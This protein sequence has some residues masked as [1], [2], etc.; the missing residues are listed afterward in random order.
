[1]AATGIFCLKSPWAY[2]QLP[3]NW[4]VSVYPGTPGEINPGWSAVKKPVDLQI[5]SANPCSGSFS[6]RYT[7]F[8]S[9]AEAFLYDFSGR[10]IMHI[11]L[12]EKMQGTVTAVLP[13]SLPVGIYFL[14]LKTAGGAASARITLLR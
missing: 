13:R 7:V 14:Y 4:E 3:W 5:V 1:V 9:T 8:S 10:V 11:E 2:F 12:P 6:F